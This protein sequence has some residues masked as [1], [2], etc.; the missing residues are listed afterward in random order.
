MGVNFDF[1]EIGSNEFDSD[2]GDAKSIHEGDDSNFGFEHIYR[3][4]STV[5][6]FEE[7]LPIGSNMG[8][9]EGNKDSK[10]GIGN[11][12]TEVK[13]V[14]QFGTVAVVTEFLFKLFHIKVVG[15]RCEPSGGRIRNSG[16]RWSIE[17]M[18]YST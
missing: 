10:N 2:C 7:V 18:E 5:N 6:N 12:T 1:D 13:S 3:N 9:K 11:S 16:G 17:N 14:Q 4:S 8:H 15:P